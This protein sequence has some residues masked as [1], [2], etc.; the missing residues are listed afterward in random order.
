MA[1]NPP[2]NMPSTKISRQ[3]QA[4]TPVTAATPPHTPAIHLST[5]DRRSR[6]IASDGSG[7]PVAPPRTRA[8]A[9]SY[10]AGVSAPDCSRRCSFSSSSAIVMRRS[11]ESDLEQQ[12]RR[13]LQRLLHRHERQHRLA[14][15]DDP[16]VVGQRKVVHRTD[17]DLPVLDNRAVLRGVD[18][19]DRAL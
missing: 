6:L 5:S 9:A 2:A 11:P 19:E 16:M 14:A 8:F 15:I 1:V 4:S 18:A 12:A 3:I 17:D 7:E 13:V 10:S